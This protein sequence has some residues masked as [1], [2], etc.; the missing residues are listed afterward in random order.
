MQINYIILVHK[1]PLQLVRLITTLSNNN[2]H[3]Y[4]HLDKNVD[5]LPFLKETNE[6]KQVSFLKEIEREFGTWGDIGIVKATINAIKKILLD[7]NKGQIVLLSGQDYPIQTNGN[8]YSFLNKNHEFSFVDSFA[9]PNEYWL[10]NGL[11]RINSYKI[12]LSHKREN[13]V[14]ISSIFDKEF[15]SKKSIKKIYALL[16]NGKFLELLNILKKRR[17]PKNLKPYGGSQWLTMTTQ[18]AK[19]VCEFLENNPKYLKY[20]KYSLLPDEMFFQTIL[21]NLADKDDTIKIK[22]H[23]L[24][25][26]NWT[27]KDCALPAIF[28]VNDLAELLECKKSDKFFAR[29]FDVNNDEEIMNLIDNSF[30]CE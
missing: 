22:N 26:A 7:D 18:T 20:H 23:S 6:L 8:I 16:I 25:Y 14:L 21:I 2:S 13:F 5:V 28:E 9:L 15:Y 3:F 10:N 19:K 4:I 27:K 17:F 24:T 29:K 11:D 1:S 30:K 12:N